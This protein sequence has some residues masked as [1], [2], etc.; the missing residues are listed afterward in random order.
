MPITNYLANKLLDEVFGG[1]DYT[2]LTHLYFGLST[3]TISLDG[4]GSTEP[5]TANG[6]AR[7]DV[8]N[9][10]VTWGT[11]GT[12]SLDNNIAVT[13]PESSSSWGTITYAFIADDPARATGN[14]LAYVALNP[15]VAVGASVTIDFAASSITISLA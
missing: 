7:V 13:F 11:A 15:P 3:T 1:T 6:Y 10:K 14:I 8:D 9:D 4:T 2:A 5:A 12:G